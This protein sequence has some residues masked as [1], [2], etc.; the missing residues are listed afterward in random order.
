MRHTRTLP[1]LVLMVCSWSAPAFAQPIEVALGFTGVGIANGSDFWGEGIKRAGVEAR[2]T[3]PIS[4]R[5]AF[6]PFV[7]YGH[8]TLPQTPSYGATVFG[9]GAGR[10]EGLYALTIKQRLAIDTPGTYAFLTYGLADYYGVTSFARTTYAYSNGN[11]YTYPAYTSTNGGGLG[12]P[13]FGGGAEKS[14]GRRA[15]VRA[16]AQVILFLFYPIGFRASVG[17]AVP[18]GRR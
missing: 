13:V 4:A 5:F 18:L 2:V 9:G 15:S 1:L 7:T 8:R 14:L 3:I 12:F 10:S 11:S 16:D 17:V 6:E